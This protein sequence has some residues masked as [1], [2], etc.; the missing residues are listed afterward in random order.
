MNIKLLFIPLLLFSSQLYAETIH[1]GILN[2]SGNEAENVLY[3]E[4]ASV[5]KD[6]L[7]PRNVEVSTY[8][9]PG[10]E[11][12]IAAGK[13]DF[14]I[15]NPGFYVSSRQKLDTTALASQSNQFFSRPDRAL[16][17]V[18]VVP[19]QN[20]NNFSLRDLK[21]KSVC[22]VAPNAYGG[23]YIALGEL[24]RRGFDP[25]KFFSSVHY[26]G[27]PM[28]KVLE[29]LKGGK[30]EAA[31]VRTCLLEELS[32]SGQIKGNEFRVI[33]PMPTSSNE[34]CIRSSELYPGWVFAA[35]KNTSEALRKE[36]TKI[37]FSLPAVQGNEWSVPRNFADLDNLYK[38]LK[39]GHY[40]Y[41][42]N[43]DW[44]EFIRN[45][46]SF[47]LIVFVVMIAVFLHNLI[48]K[49][50]VER[51]TER[52]R[53]TMKEKMAEHQAAVSANRH[54]HDM[55]KINLVGMLSSMIAHELRQPLTVI[56][57]YSEGLRDI[58]HSQDY[59]A[60]VL[61][62]ALKV[63]DEQ[64]VRASSIIEHMRGLIKGKESK[65]REVD[66]NSSVPSIL[67]TYK[68]LGGKYEVNLVASGNAAVS[69]RIDTQFEIVLLNLLNN[70]SEAIT[71]QETKPIITLEISGE[72]GEAAVT[73]ANEGFLEHEESFN[74]LFAVKNS[75]K[76]NG[77]GL[78]LA[79]AARVVER[80][81]GQLSIRQHNKEVIAC[82]LL[83]SL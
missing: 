58:L 40:E 43:W 69:V 66:L 62:E 46:W 73:V 64:S 39:V 51:K 22:A 6:K 16:G 70:A 11:K 18:F 42:R 63:V 61:E 47:I 36:T 12:A 28:P 44:K 13:L 74:N 75:T 35:T 48:L 56:R 52:L 53:Q 76:V 19:Q 79:I 15:S 14:F 38:N 7:K 37:L 59:D 49:Q 77:L 33:E 23:L 71:Q 68:E 34:Y 54:L 9:L 55:E 57:N 24:N 45:Y 80:W 17:S 25:D 21:G 41:L 5:L 78:G 20:N 83:P 4:T 67:E 30:C 82:I 60:K 65:V 27:Y 8:D 29:D 81:G 1:L 72:N 31:I 3:A 2:T 32:S 50:Q 10:L 26:S